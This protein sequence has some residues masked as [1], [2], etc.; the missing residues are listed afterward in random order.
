VPD[1]RREFTAKSISITVRGPDS[2]IADK[3]QSEQ[4]DVA[5]FWSTFTFG[6]AS[7]FSPP[8]VAHFVVST[9]TRRL[10]SV[11]SLSGQ[12]APLFANCP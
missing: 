1:Q 10:S 2:A 9:V 6:R 12:G 11:R 7:P 3:Q 5:P 8:L 4:S